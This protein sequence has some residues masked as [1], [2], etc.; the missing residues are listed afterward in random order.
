MTKE[1]VTL[2]LDAA[3]VEELRS[4]AGRR[5]LSASVDAAVAAHV[6]RLRHLASVDG[7]LAELDRAH[8]PVAAETLDW[9][10]QLVDGWHAG[11]P[12][13]GRPAR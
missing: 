4:L 6:A 7:W 10:A 13:P 11:R 12:E 3:L 8:G 9:A 1:K 5:S 2:T